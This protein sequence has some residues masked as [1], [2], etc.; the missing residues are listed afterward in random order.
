MRELVPLGAQ[1]KPM[2]PLFLT[3][4]VDKASSQCMYNMT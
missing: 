2:L 3:S 4:W 1:V